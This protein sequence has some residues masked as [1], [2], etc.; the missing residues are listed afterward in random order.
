[1]M[2]IE[3]INARINELD[4]MD[5][6]SR[7]PANAACVP[8]MRLSLAYPASFVKQNRRWAEVFKNTSQFFHGKLLCA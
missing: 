1:M 6:G 4:I 7:A 2:Q 3:D 8:L 5:D